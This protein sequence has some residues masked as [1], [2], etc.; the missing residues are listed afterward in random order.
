MGLQGLIYSSP[1][2]TPGGWDTGLSLWV[3]GTQLRCHQGSGERGSRACL[4]TLSI[5][6]FC[7]LYINGILPRVTFGV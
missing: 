1:F 4:L 2:Q 5:N 3:G 7:T 6:L